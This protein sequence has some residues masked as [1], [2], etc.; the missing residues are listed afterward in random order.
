MNCPNCE[1]YIE[2]GK[3]CTNCGTEL[4]V[5]AATTETADPV[6]VEPTQ[7]NIQQE[8]V[9]SASIEKKEGAGLDIADYY[10]RLVKKPAQAL[11]TTAN[12]LIPGII[13]LVVFALLIGSESYYL[14]SELAGGY[15][16]PS[17]TDDFLVPFLRFGLVLV[18]VVAFTFWGLKFTANELSFQ[19]V[20]AKY[21][22][23]LI[24]FVLLFALGFILEVINLPSIPNAVMGVSSNAPLLVIPTLIILN[25]KKKE[26]DLIYLLVG[27]FA[28]SYIVRAL[29]LEALTSIFS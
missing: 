16:S 1:E 10:T 15:I 26:I 27:I 9:Q 25:S 11:E 28:A 23:F 5:D 2:E 18:A 19:D 4:T 13:T 7:E 8:P 12:D 24:P 20:F 14:M 17:F 3:F 6:N 22:A 29:L 21:T